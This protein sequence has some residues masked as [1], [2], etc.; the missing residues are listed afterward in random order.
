MKVVRPQCEARICGRTPDRGLMPG[1]GSVSLYFGQ[2]ARLNSVN[3][4]K[5]RRGKPS[6]TKPTFA[7]YRCQFEMVRK[8]WRKWLWPPCSCGDPCSGPLVQLTLALGWHRLL[9][10]PLAPKRAR[11]M[12]QFLFCFFSFFFK[13]KWFK[14]NDWTLCSITRAILT[15]YLFD[16]MHGGGYTLVFLF[17]P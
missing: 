17:P 11:Q 13:V 12:W 7:S 9:D 10:S 15:E 4:M 8:Q 1:I 14:P 3:K 6:I 2:S 16:F 5:R